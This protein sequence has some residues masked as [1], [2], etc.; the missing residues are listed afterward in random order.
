MA[1]SLWL[2][3]TN[4]F[5]FTVF[6]NHFLQFISAEDLSQI[7]QVPPMWAEKSG[8]A[9]TALCPSEA[10]SRSICKLRVPVPANHGCP[11]GLEMCMERSPHTPEPPRYCLWSFP[12]LSWN[13]VESSGHILQASTM[14]WLLNT[15]GS[16][17]CI[18]LGSGVQRIVLWASLTDWSWM[19]A[20]LSWLCVPALN[21][22][23]EMGQL[24]LYRILHLTWHILENSYKNL[25]TVNSPGHSPITYYAKGYYYSFYIPKVHIGNVIVSLICPV[26]STPPKKTSQ[27]DAVSRNEA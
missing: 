25:F 4:P 13:V 3:G 14:V 1:S 22:S 20:T 16:S 6:E 7:S 10:I 23:R 9:D 18:F 8:F 19:C 17:V 2:K 27:P 15:S 21:A 12:L 5:P 24:L 26:T 11:L